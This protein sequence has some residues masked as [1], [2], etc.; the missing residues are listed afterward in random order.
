MYYEFDGS[1]KKNGEFLLNFMAN[2]DQVN[3]AII[4]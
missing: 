2:L 1:I 4:N 3:K